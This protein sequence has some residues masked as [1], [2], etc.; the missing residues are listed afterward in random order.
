MVLTA[1]SAGIDEAYVKSSLKTLG[2]QERVYNFFNFGTITDLLWERAAVIPF[3]FFA[4]FFLSLIRPLALK[5]MAAFAVLREELKRH[6]PEQIFGENRKIILKPVLYAIGLA[7]FPVS[8][9]FLFL[10]L[11]SIC[12]PWQD[13]PSLALLNRELFYPHLRQLCDYELASCLLF[14]ISLAVLGFLVA[15]VNILLNRN[16]V[17]DTPEARML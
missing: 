6:Y 7:L 13:I 9:L 16:S 10:R 1:S 5:F 4:L 12:L 15:G 8:S 14:F 11:A 3:L 2:I 17:S